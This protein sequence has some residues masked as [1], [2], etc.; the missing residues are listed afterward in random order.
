[1]ITIS[2]PLP[3]DAEGMN[4]VIKHSWY[5]T[6]TTPEIG[7][8]KEDIDAIYAES[9]QQQIDV[10]RKRAEKESDTDVTLV[11]KEG[12]AVVGIIR[13]VDL[14]DHVR[15]RTFYVDPKHAGKGIGTSLWNDV[16][17]YLPKDKDVVAWPTEHTKSIDFYKK[18]GFV[19]TG[20]KEQGEP[21]PKSGARMTIQKMV[22]DRSNNI[23]NAPS[24]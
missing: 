18:I 9:E 21:M 12:T 24:H 17:Q 4:D 13:V 2:K 6:Y 3:E 23:T 10:F 8:T 5:A 19:T 22:F 7:I 14:G 15:V 1:M 16:L 11:A 20:E